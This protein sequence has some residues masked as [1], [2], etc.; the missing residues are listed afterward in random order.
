MLQQGTIL[1]LHILQTLTSSKIQKLTDYESC[2]LFLDS[3]LLAN[4]LEKVGE[5]HFIFENKSFTTA[6]CLKESHICIHTWPEINRVTMDVYLCN[7]SGNN[8]QKVHDI[9]KEIAFFFEAEIVS[10]NEI[11]R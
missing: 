1:G 10:S 8:N 3:L 11:Y 5:S 6:I 2:H 9:S 4:K 7:Y